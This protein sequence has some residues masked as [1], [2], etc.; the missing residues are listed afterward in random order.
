[1]RT[2][3]VVR[4]VPT[5]SLHDAATQLHCFQWGKGLSVDQG[6]VWGPVACVC[7]CVRVLQAACI[8]PLLKSV[9]VR[10]GRTTHCVSAQANAQMCTALG[11]HKQRT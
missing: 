3:C 1:M 5:R 11:V 6:P 9:W 4:C 8:T 7:V 10:T 2:G